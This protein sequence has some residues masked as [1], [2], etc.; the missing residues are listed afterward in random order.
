MDFESSSWYER[1]KLKG[2]DHAL[3]TKIW[4]EINLTDIAFDCQFL[5]IFPKTVYLQTIYF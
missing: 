3:T 1:D 2:L 5:T 4:G